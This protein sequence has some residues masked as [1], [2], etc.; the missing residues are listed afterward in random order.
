MYFHI[1]SSVNIICYSMRCLTA[2]NS[3]VVYCVMLDQEAISVTA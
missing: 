2:K 1:T 3:I